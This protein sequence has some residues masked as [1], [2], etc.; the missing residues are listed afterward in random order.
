M[1]VVT[2]ILFLLLL[3]CKS[4]NTPLDSAITELEK[5][6]S[7]EDLKKFASKSEEHALGDLHFSGELNDSTLT[8]YFYSR[9]VKNI[10]YIGNILYSS[11]HRKLN[12]KPI[13]INEQII[14]YQTLDDDAPASPSLQLVQ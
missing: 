11:L 14:Y 3:N 8:K 1:R 9:G 5:S 2:F 4:E 6:F 12:N 7:K 13:N 10:E